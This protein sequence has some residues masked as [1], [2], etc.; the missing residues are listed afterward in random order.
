VVQGSGC[1]SLFRQDQEGRI[2]AGKHNLMRKA[3]SDRA[4]VMVVEKPGVR[5][6]DAPGSNGTS[7]NCRPA[8]LR[9]H[10]LESWRDAIIAAIK[11]AVTHE[12]VNSS[13]LAMVGHSEGAIVAAAVAAHE[14]AVEAVGFLSGSGAGQ[15]YD[16]VLSARRGAQEKGAPPEKVQ[17][18]VERVY[19][20]YRKVMTSPRSTKNFA[21]GHPFRRW[22]SFLSHSASDLLMQTKA[23]LFLAHG[24][25]DQIVPIESFDN[26]V[27]DLVR[28]GRPDVTVRYL[29]GADHALTQEKHKTAEASVQHIF[30]DFIGWWLEEEP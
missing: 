12:I 9:Q 27:C 29:R 8:F 22:S 1:H 11:D 26:L 14:P 13:R 18:T 23:R 4:A 3:A 17:E 28:L 16:L 6:L 10:T 25:E 30:Q 21:W 19:A 20:T 15:L 7:R 24:T 2:L 5:F